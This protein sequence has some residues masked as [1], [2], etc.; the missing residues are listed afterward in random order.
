MTKSPDISEQILQ[1]GKKHGIG[2]QFDVCPIMI[3]YYKKPEETDS[4][5][6]FFVVK[7]QCELLEELAENKYIFMSDR[8]ANKIYFP[9]YHDNVQWFDSATIMIS[10]TKAG[11]QFLEQETI[12]QSN[13][14]LNAALLRNI[15]IQWILGVVTVIIAI[16]GACMAWLNYELTISSVDELQRRVKQLETQ[17]TKPILPQHISTPTSSSTQPSIPSK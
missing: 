5:K 1:E 15:R 4:V 2:K 9:T 17:S 11:I 16:F 7:P 8:L 10:I 13:L 14:N 6:W 12:N 3:K